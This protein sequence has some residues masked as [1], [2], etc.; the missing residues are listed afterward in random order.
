MSPS[1][2][3]CFLGIAIPTAFYFKT[4]TSYLIGAAGF[5]IPIVAPGFIALLDPMPIW[6]II[7]PTASQFKLILIAT[8]AGSASTIEIAAMFVVSAIA[9]SGTVWFAIRRLKQ[10]LGQK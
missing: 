5:L 6:A 2:Q 1:P 3:S 7:I 4:V 10:E 8:N 9:A